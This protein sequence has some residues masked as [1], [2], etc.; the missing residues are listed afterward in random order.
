MEITLHDNS[1]LAFTRVR[2]GLLSVE[3]YRPGNLKDGH[4]WLLH[5]STLLEGEEL[6]EFLAALTG[7][8]G[9]EP[10]LAVLRTAA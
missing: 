8:Q 5:G 4:G 3:L 10:Q 2:P 9:P 7:P 6:R 1:K